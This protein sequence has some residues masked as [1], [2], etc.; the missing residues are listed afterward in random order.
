MFN[1]KY[2]NKN[3]LIYCGPERCDC[4][5]GNRNNIPDCLSCKGTGRKDGTIDLLRL[6]IKEEDRC[7]ICKGSGMENY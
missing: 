1:K 3:C 7:L 2:Q 5:N 6:S 4:I